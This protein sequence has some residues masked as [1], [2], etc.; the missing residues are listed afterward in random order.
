M[1][2][3]CRPYFWVYFSLRLDVPSHVEI[4]LLCSAPSAHPCILVLFFSN[5]SRHSGV[6][7]LL[8]RVWGESPC[9]KEKILSTCIV[10][11]SCR[12]SNFLAIWEAAKIEP[13]KPLLSAQD[14]F[15]NSGSPS[16]GLA[17]DMLVDDLVI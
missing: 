14:E 10:N 15:K 11:F 13:K 16:T 3:W 2:E 5:R 12:R 4:L 8:L 1:G 9:W 17:P 6:V 7:R